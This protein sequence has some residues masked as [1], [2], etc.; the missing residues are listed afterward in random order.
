M[1]WHVIRPVK[2]DHVLLQG[3]EAKNIL[4]LK[5]L[6]LAIFTLGVNHVSIPITIHSTDETIMLEGGIIKV[7]QHGIFGRVIHRQIMIRSSERLS[8]FLM[9]IHATGTP[10]KTP[11]NALWQGRPIIGKDPTAQYQENHPRNE[12]GALET[13]RRLTDQ[14]SLRGQR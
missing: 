10:D 12:R 9:A 4:D 2:L 3:R 7:S 1:W 13:K 11:F 6:H 14:E 8:L 5:V